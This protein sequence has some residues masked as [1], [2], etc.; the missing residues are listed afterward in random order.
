MALLRLSVI[1][2]A[3]VVQLFSID[4]FLHT[5]DVITVQL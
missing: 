2:K 4:Q 3:T 1:V 5:V